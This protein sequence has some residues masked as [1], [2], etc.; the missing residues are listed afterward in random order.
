MAAGIKASADGLYGTLQVNSADVVTFNSSGNVGIGTSSPSVDFEVS[1]ATGSASPTPTEIR[2]S[3][4]TVASDYSTTLP[5]GRLSFYSADSSGAGPKIHA[6]IDT[7]A[8]T[9]AGGSS[10]LSFKTQSNTLDTLTE[11]FRVLA[12]AGT[13]ESLLELTNGTGLSIGRT[14]VTSP[15]TSDG[16]V[17]SGTYT[18]TLTNTTNV[19]ASTAYACQYMRVGNVVTVS[20]RVNIDATTT[21]TNTTL[22]VSLPVASN[23]A[24]AQNAGGTFS[25]SSAAQSVSG[26]IFADSTNDRASFRILIDSAAAADYYFTFTYQV[27]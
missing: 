1:S 20:G 22:G 8:F 19:A 6:A 17:Y 23:F 25:P 21:A 14:N 11:R 18:P 12:V 5:W 27:I 10:H 2:I 24:A 16:N 4:T 3:T 26:V 7:T 13:G 15:A 9:T